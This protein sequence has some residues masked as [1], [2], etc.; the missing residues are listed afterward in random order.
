MTTG[1]VIY[2]AAVLVVL[3]YF[4]GN[5]DRRGELRLVCQANERLKARVRY[6]QALVAATTEQLEDAS[7]DF[8]AWDREIRGGRL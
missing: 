6:Y 5:H 3:A 4:A 7:A 8:V 2:A 1:V